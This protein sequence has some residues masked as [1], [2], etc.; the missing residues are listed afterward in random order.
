[1]FFLSCKGVLKDQGSSQSYWKNIDEEQCY[2]KQKNKLWNENCTKSLK[3]CIN[4]EK[5]QIK[6][7]RNCATAIAC[8][9]KIGISH[10]DICNRFSKLIWKWT[11]R[12]G[13]YTI[14]AQ[15]PGLKNIGADREYKELSVELILYS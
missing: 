4:E 14:A 9:N 8:I 10:L 15:I 13:I 6:L 12:K 11:E 7:F 5:I 2:E 3:P 1:M